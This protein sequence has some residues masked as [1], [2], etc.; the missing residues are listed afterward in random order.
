[1]FQNSLKTIQAVSTNAVWFYVTF[2]NVDSYM[3]ESS[4]NKIN[5]ETV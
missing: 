3:G 5:G 2:I 1:M 4:D